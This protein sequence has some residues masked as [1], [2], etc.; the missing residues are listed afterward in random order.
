MLKGKIDCSAASYTRAPKEIKSR[1]WGN[2]IL[3]ERQAS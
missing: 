3:T 2:E 1:T